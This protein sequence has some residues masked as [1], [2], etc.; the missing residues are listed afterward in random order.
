MY[1]LI[2]VFIGVIAGFIMFYMTAIERV[3]ILKYLLQ[4]VNST[5]FYF[6]IVILVPIICMVFFPRVKVFGYSTSIT[7]IILFILL[8]IAFNT[9]DIGF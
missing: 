7:M 1:T 9:G 6:I 8:Y 4:Y 5:L 3:K 2:Q